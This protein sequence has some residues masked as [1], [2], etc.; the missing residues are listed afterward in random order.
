MKETPHSFVW[1]RKK[2][3][4]TINDHRLGKCQIQTKKDRDESD[5]VTDKNNEVNKL[6]FTGIEER[7][8]IN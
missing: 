1:F 7:E 2:S 4:N 8:K 6:D 5:I 3:S